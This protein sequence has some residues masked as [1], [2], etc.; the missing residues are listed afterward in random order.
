MTASKLGKTVNVSES[1]VVRFA[2]ELGYDGYPAMQKTLQEM[3][4]S[5]LTTIQRIEVS[6]DRMGDHDVLST[7]VQSDIEKL[8][9]SLEEINRDDFAAAVEA[10]R[11]L[12]VTEIICVIL[13]IGVVRLLPRLKKA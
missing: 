9:I 2:A 1:T 5:K 8:R 6:N 10:I 3:I 12:S 4:R 11:F 13:G 7:V